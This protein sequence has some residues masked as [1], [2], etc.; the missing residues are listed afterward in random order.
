M[1]MHQIDPIKDPRWEV[2]L[3]RHPCSSVFHSAAWLA[4][5]HKTYG[6]E[7]VAYTTTRPGTELENGLV[8][9]R[10]DSWLTGRRLVSLP[11]SD[12]CHPLV[13]RQ[14]NLVSLLQGLQRIQVD[15]R[16][17][18]IEIRPL[19]SSTIE[20]GNFAAAESVYLHKVDLRPSL[21]QLFR[22]L[23]KDSIQRKIRRAER[24]GLI[25]EEGR[26]EALL[27]KF[28]RLMLLTRRRHE[29]PPASL[30]WFRN[31]GVCMGEKFTIR[32]ACKNE[33][34]IAAVLILS[35]K[36]TVVYK[37]GCSDAE[38]HNFGGMPFL[39]WKTI[40]NAKK[41]GAEELDLGRSDID[42][43]GLVQFKER[44]GA[45]RST[46]TYV[47]FPASRARST[48]AGW[49]MQIAKL[50]VSYLPDRCLITA[51]RLLYPHIG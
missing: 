42:N 31:L 4:A 33:R 35:H 47:K 3:E 41:E 43:S 5:L 38:F 51:G 48:S 14:E 11:F 36:N 8:F 1:T 39:L 32:V 13:D 19:E 29:L 9:C 6:Y 12:H 46:L 30:D 24:E 40:E 17:K 45:S 2:F 44:L 49:K 28:Y 26:S 23:H 15:E 10:I 20:W 25:C 22:N 34:P 37:Y 21:E 18:C 7:P 50:V 27:S 16:L